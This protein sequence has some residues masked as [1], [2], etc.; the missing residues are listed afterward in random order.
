MGTSAQIE[1]LVRK[2]QGKGLN[3]DLSIGVEMR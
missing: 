1:A 3:L 2:N